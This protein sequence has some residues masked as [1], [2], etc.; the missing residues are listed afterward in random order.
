MWPTIQEKLDYSPLQSA[1]NFIQNGA[2]VI[3][4]KGTD[5]KGKTYSVTAKS[6]EVISDC[7]YILKNV[8]LEITPPNKKTI[9]VKA[10]KVHYHKALK[11]ADLEG[12][13]ELKTEDGFEL[14][15][16]TAHVNIEKSFAEGEESV[17][18]FKNGSHIKAIGFK[19][20]DLSGN[21]K[22]K[23]RPTFTRIK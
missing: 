8:I 14:K 19:M 7:E 23:G 11:T 1:L 13:V 3:K 21:V 12:K 6:V 10:N 16:S 17:E 20:E 22:F 5:Q 4:Y 15:T 2:Q 9:T 18:C